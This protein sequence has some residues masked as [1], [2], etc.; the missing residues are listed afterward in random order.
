MIISQHNTKLKRDKPIYYKIRGVARTRIQSYT[1]HNIRVQTLLVKFCLKKASTNHIRDTDRKGEASCLG[2][3]ETTPG[4]RGTRRRSSRLRGTPA[5]GL[6]RRLQRPI[7]QNKE[8][9][10]K[11]R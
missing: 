1:N 10:I 2:A 9:E 11:Q 3:S 7:R 6:Q 4:Q 5:P 8:E